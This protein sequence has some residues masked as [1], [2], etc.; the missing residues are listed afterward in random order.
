MAHVGASERPPQPNQTS[1]TSIAASPSPRRSSSPS[2]HGRRQGSDYKN[3]YPID[4]KNSFV[5][6]NVEVGLPDSA[7]EDRSPPSPA[8]S[9][10]RRR[11]SARQ[12]A[13]ELAG[14]RGAD[15]ALD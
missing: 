9:S 7:Q 6:K 11:P 8:G 15:L 12:L 14:V 13:Q 1:K 4:T 3:A 5:S 2:T 10:R